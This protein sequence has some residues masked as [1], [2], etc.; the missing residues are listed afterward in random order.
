[1][2]LLLLAA[3]LFLESWLL[4]KTGRLVGVMPVIAWVL[5]TACFGIWV[6]QR[7]GISTL[8]RVQEAAARQ[9]LPT[10]ALLEGLIVLIAGLLLISPGLIGDLAGITLLIA[11]LRRGLAQ[12]LGAG[13]SQ[14]RPDLKKPVTLEG[15][16]RRK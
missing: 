7:Q 12:R 16:F 4:V 10:D 8:R 1:M 6:I 15:E 2:R 5:A 13:I 14:A 3:F 11:G 9:E